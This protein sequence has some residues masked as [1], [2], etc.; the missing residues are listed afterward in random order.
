M[1][2]DALKILEA[3]G[4][5][6]VPEGMHCVPFKPIIQAT[7]FD[8]SKTRRIVRLLAR[9]DL[10]EY[11]RGL[12][13]DDGDFAGAGYCITNA[14]QALLEEKGIKYDENGLVD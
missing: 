14:G 9:K 1:T 11:W 8:R 5:K 3:L 4:R 7:G 6:T 10:A 13:T 12:C 2:A